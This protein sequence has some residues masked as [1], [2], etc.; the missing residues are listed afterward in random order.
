M[1]EF[2]S[3]L[4]SAPADEGIQ[5]GPTMNTRPQLTEEDAWATLL[6]LRG[7]AP[8]E[9]VLA[10][11]G[12]T[13]SALAPLSPAARQ[14]FDLFLPILLAPAADGPMV[15]AHLAQSLDG[16][17]ATET[18]TSQWITGPEDITHCHRLRALCDAVLVGAET[19]LLDDPRLTVR[20]VSGPDPLRVIVDPARRVPSDRNVFIDGRSPTVVLTACPGP[21]SVGDARV[22]QVCDHEGELSSEAILRAL[23][24]LGVRRLYIE[25]GG[26]TVSRFLASGCL[27]RLHI[28]VAP[29]LLGSGRPSVVLPAVD[30]LDGVARPTTATYKLGVDM[31]FDCELG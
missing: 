26:V 24:A 1:C 28:A 31:L 30:T 27:N 6:T 29:M 13:W 10:I 14:L 18:G 9:D 22:I 16:R 2:D 25:G 20:R 12:S 23:S 15:V 11:E 3:A 4:V 17:I 19:A 21:E 8:V 5:W 7:G